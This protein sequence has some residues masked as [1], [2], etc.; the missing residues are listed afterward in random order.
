MVL[1]TPWDLSAMKMADYGSGDLS[2]QGVEDLKSVSHV[3][4]FVQVESNLFDNVSGI[5]SLIHKMGRQTQLPLAMEDGPVDRRPSP[6]CR[7]QAG[8]KVHH[9]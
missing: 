7:K 6:V 1:G 2:V 3:L 9:A 4:I 5:H 8:M